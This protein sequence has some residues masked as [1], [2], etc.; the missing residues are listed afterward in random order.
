MLWIALAFLFGLGLVDARDLVDAA[1]K[2]LK[3]ALTLAD[4]QAF[5]RR[6]KDAGADVEVK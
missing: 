1:P 2:E 5:A 4:A 6:L 3:S